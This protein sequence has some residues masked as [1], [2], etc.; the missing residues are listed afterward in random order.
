LPRNPLPTMYADQLL[1]QP[2]CTK[3]ASAC[4]CAVCGPRPATTAL[5]TTKKAS[6]KYAMP[7]LPKNPSTTL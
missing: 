5:E 3:F 6:Q 7:C 1:Y 2:P 4:N